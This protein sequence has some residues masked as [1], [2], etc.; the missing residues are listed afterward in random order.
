VFLLLFIV[1]IIL[2]LLLFH[3]LASIRHAVFLW[4]R[5]PLAIVIGGIA[6]YYIKKGLDS[7]FGHE[8]DSISLISSGVFARVRHPIYFGSIALYLAFV[9]LTL[10]VLGFCLWIVIV[11]FYIVSSRYEE[12][13]LIGIIGRDYIDY[14]QKVPMLFPLVMR[15]KD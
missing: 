11:V 14:I 3:L 13:E 12:K 8:R 6:C 9:V 5:I 1:V 15:R 7:V 2:D 4:I 10:S